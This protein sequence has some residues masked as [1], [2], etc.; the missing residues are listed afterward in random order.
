M[1][2]LAACGG[3]TVKLF[4]SSVKPGDP[5]SL[6]YAPSLGF[7]V[8]S[9][10]WNHTTA[11]FPNGVGDSLPVSSIGFF[12]FHFAN[13]NERFHPQ[14]ALLPNLLLRLSPSQSL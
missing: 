2:L 3:D 4:D 6:S 10:K 14:R 1:A 12:S 11:C 8:N 13:L 7:Q 9:V 5:C